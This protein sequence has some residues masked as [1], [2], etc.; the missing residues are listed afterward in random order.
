MKYEPTSH[1]L[2]NGVTVILDPMD[3]ETV[4]VKIRFSTGS[5][6]EKTEN[7]GITHFCEHMLFKGTKRFASRKD[8][9]DFIDN[10][11]GQFNASTSVRALQLYGRIIAE[12]TNDLLELFADMLQNSVFDNQKIEI[13]RGV[14]LDERRQAVCSVK[15][16]FWDLIDTS[17]FGWPHFQTIGSEENIKSF[18]R[19]QMLNWLNERL[20]AQNCIICISGRIDDKEKLLEKLESLY[21]FL[22]NRKVSTNK[23]LK[24]TPCDKFLYDSGL[25][26]VWLCIA[27]PYIRPDTYENTF[28]DIAESK[29][30][31]YLSQEL[32]EALRHQNG[33]VYGLGV[34]SY[35]NEINGVRG[36][37]TE[38]SPENL[39]RAVALIAKTAYRVYYKD[40][41]TQQ[42]IDRITNSHKLADADFLEN[43]SQRRDLLV[44]NWADFGVLY[45]YNRIIEMDRATCVKDVI[46]ASTG[47]FDGDMSIISFG[48]KHNLDLRKI[49]IDNFK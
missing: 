2:S 28:K 15:R 33:L 29:F 34:S 13:E 36:I 45:E 23:E 38:T 9:K 39:E 1:K 26:N 14:I 21:S 5:R 42:V 48:A 11:G 32:N 24:Y 17:L 7:H 35:G 43:A 47:F 37:E 31:K 4:A 27:F 46:E 6:D 22:P 40:K 49:W 19:E 25:K 8:L 12:N 41:I 30:R 20:S 44:A 18:T 3:I 10:K 16:K